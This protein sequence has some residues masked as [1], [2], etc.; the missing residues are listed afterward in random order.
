MKNLPVS[1]GA[2]SL[3]RELISAASA[4][5]AA[6]GITSISTR[7]FITAA[8]VMMSGNFLTVEA[9]VGRDGTTRDRCRQLIF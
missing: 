2:T 7:K 5:A 8:A 1:S 6:D 4:A 9:F 3:Y